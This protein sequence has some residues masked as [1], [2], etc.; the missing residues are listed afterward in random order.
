MPLHIE[1]L[2]T[3]IDVITEAAPAGATAQRSDSQ[4]ERERTRRAAERALRIDRR[5]GAEGYDD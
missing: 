5:T 4:A 1:E 3:T 2:T